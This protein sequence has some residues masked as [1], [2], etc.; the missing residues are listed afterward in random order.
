MEH[1]DLKAFV[2]KLTPTFQNTE[3]RFGSCVGAGDFGVVKWATDWTSGVH[4][5]A[6]A[7]I[8][9]SSPPRPDRLSVPPSLLGY[10]G[11]FPWQ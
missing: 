11:S 9:L 10:R 5:P 7:I 2:T 6:E 4:F 3:S 8:E 1:V